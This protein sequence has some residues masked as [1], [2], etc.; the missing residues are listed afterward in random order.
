MRMLSPMPRSLRLVLCTLLFIGLSAAGAPAPATAQT[1]ALQSPADFLGYELGSQFTSHHRVVDYVEH[2]AEQSPN[3]EIERYGESYQGR[4]L[5]VA[6]VSSPELLEQRDAIRQDN[7]RR[8]GLA[9]GTPGELAPAIVWLS[10]NV[11][12]NESVSTESSMQTLFELAD[13][14]NTQT[15]PWLD[16]TVVIIDPLMNPDGRE[17][18]VNFYNRT[19]G[20]T[21][22]PNRIARELQEDWPSGRSNHYY[23]DLNRDWAWATQQETQQRLDLYNQWMPHVHVD[24]HEQSIDAPH[25]FAPA[26]DPFHEDI[27]EWQRSFQETVGR[28]HTRYF[29]DNNW[30]Y[31]TRER[32]DLFYPGFGDTW[33]TFNGAIGMTY[34]QGG[35]GRAGLMVHTLEG[36]TLTLHDRFI[37]HHVTG[38][39]TVETAAREADDLVSSFVSHFEETAANPPGDYAAYLIKA[40]DAASAG[41]PNTPDDRVHALHRHL[42]RQGIESTIAGP[43]TD[44]STSGLRY[45]DQTNQSVSVEPGDLVVSLSQPKSRLAK[46]LME[47]QTTVVDSVTYDM[48]GW[49]L[50]YAYGLDAY[51]LG[52]DVSVSGDTQAAPPALQGNDTDAPYAYLANW[53]SIADAAFLADLLESD[54]KVRF[55]REAFE[56]EGRTFEPGTLVI[57]RTNNRAMGER[58]DGIVQETAAEHERSL[59]R[60]ATGFMDEAPDFGSA[61]IRY[62]DAPHVGVLAGEPLASLN[63]GEIWHFFDQQLQYPATLLKPGNFQDAWLD[64]LDVLVMPEGQY[65][66]WLSDERVAALQQWIERGGHL[67]AFGS[68][69]SALSPYDGFALAAPVPDEDVEDEAETPE[70]H[71]YEDR[72]RDAA[73]R[74]TPGSVH[75][76]TLDTSHPLA[77]GIEQYFTMK[78][79]TR[80]FAYLDDGWTVA[81]LE[82]APPL[83]GFM[84]HEAQQE[85]DDTLVFGVQ[86]H[87]QGRITYL[88]DN[89]LVRGF[90]HNGQLLMSNAVFFVGNE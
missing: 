88:V 16:N 53:H 29:D 70:L 59:Y 73:T 89:P 57:L 5:M 83:T 40:R 78:R 65:S 77:F 64:E 51:A 41:V 45:A 39:S 9:D 48:T 36:D 19:A 55:A 38:L 76:T 21:P 13:P 63:V 1:D 60:T 82:D 20:A 44:A 18:Y 23:F 85:L 33:P 68:A 81:A 35:S 79:S 50:P 52:S 8:I 32:F 69:S 7:L 67:I 11:H 27:A 46:V 87:G 37:R 34:E 12:G 10:Y 30:R 14:S 31:F 49:S 6:Y 24:Y 26:A 80:A 71:R 56:F 17:R 75:A 15:Q 28:N 74:G 47:P 66:D 42:E 90:W 72:A 43:G 58:F 25:Y 4:P 86:P 54:V 3:V 84:G 62:I 2:V 22:N 61:N